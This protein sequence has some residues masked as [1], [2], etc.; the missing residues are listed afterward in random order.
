MYYHYSV[1]G[2]IILILDLWAIVTIINSGGDVGVKILWILL[3]LFL[4]VIGL[5]LWYLL[6]R[7]RL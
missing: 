4:P 3:I 6:G 1:V 2:I 5:I 7:G